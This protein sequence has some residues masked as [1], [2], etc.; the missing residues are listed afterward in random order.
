VSCGI[1]A[2]S[3]GDAADR[4]GEA[5][6]RRA[7]VTKRLPQSLV[8]A[9]DESPILRIRAGAR[10]EHRFTGIWAV[11]VDGRAFARSW[12]RK[13][14]G[15]YQT[16]L[17]DPFGTIQVRDRQVQVRAVRVRGT[18]IHDDIERA[19]ANKY[20]T[21]ASLKYVR[22]FRNKRRRETTMEFVRP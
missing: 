11:V 8:R 9:I 10:S 1:L 15:W 18:R 4:E 3:P 2:Q 7:A 21:P 17:D 5:S 6:S 20:T 12:M 16:F 19:Y 14:G 22:G 13:A